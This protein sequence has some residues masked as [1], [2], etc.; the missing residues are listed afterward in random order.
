MDIPPNKHFLASLIPDNMYTI[1]LWHKYISI[2][3]R[4]LV[5]TVNSPWCLQEKLDL[6][7]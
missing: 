6:K 2:Y 4:F 1:F 3:L 7:D 5:I